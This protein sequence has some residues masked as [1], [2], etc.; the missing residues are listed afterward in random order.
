LTRTNHCMMISW[1]SLPRFFSG[2][3]TAA[4]KLPSGHAPQVHV[5]TPTSRSNQQTKIKVKKALRCFC[6]APPGW[7]WWSKQHLH[8]SQTFT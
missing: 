4:G 3:P 6:Q 5:V 8:L 1:R 2:A 7:H